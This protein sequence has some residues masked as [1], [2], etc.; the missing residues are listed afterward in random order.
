MAIYAFKYS[1]LRSSLQGA[2][3]SMELHSRDQVAYVNVNKNKTTGTSEYQ[4]LH[5][6]PPENTGQYQE[7]VKK[8]KDT[9][10]Q[11]LL[12]KTLRLK[13]KLLVAKTIDVDLIISITY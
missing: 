12:Q 6:T 8:Q 3:S 13:I 2:A 11:I 1:K 4:D 10:K 5:L 7:L 9:V